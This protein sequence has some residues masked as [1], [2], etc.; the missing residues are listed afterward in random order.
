MSA[1]PNKAPRGRPVTFNTH[2]RDVYLDHVAR[3]AK[4][5]EAAAAAGITPRWATHLATLDPQFAAARQHA[6]TQGRHARMNEQ[7]HGEYRYIHGKCR[8][9]ICT[10]EATEA[11]T[12]RRN[13]PTETT[14]PTTSPE[15]PTV[16]DMPK[17]PAQLVTSFPL[18]RAS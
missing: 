15:T 2:Q 7:P 10:K 3:G 8:C 6:R 9:D 13:R 18:A 16:V 17:Q 11:R 1:L 5:S 14:S 12:H 4:L